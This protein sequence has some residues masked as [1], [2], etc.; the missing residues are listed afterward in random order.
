MFSGCVAQQADVV[1]INRDLNKKIARLDKSKKDLQQAVREANEALDKANSIIAQQRE[2]IQTL[3][4]ARAD[5]N[6]Q[7]MTLKDGDL[8]EVRG[9]ID[10]NRH[11]LELLSQQIEGLNRQVGL[12]QKE[13]LRRDETIQ[14]IVEQIRGQVT[15]QEAVVT[16]QAEKMTE[17]RTSF[18]DFQQALA[19]LR[20]TIGQQ[21]SLI[22]Q[23]N[24]QIELV[25]GKQ[26]T[27]NQ[28]TTQNFEEVKRSINSVVSALDKVSNTLANRL[29]EQDQKLNQI[30]A[31]MGNSPITSSRSTTI[32]QSSQANEISQ[33]VRQLR[34]EMNTLAMNLEPRQDTRRAGLGTSPPSRS[35]L[36]VPPVGYP[37]ETSDYVHVPSKGQRA[38]GIRHQP[39]ADEAIREYG[40]HYALLRAGDV[41]GAL[42]G[43]RQFLERYPNSPLASNAQYW[44]GE[45]YYAQRR[46]SQAIVEF[47]RVFNQY[48]SSEKVPAA[49]LKIGYSNLEL[50]EHARARAI[51]RQ[52]VRA[53][54]KTPEAAK[55][56]SRLTEFERMHNTSP[57]S[58]PL[59]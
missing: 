12:Y 42:K 23:A 19:T 37:Q 7:M 10:E 1:R 29:D 56:Y 24:S 35:P 22:Q 28:S 45:C 43:F 40:E 47:E 21:D 52:L 41:N 11:Q 8:S 58:G 53:Y 31:R 54:P 3:L 48:P 20:E 32:Q 34:E 17:F 49:L 14:P 5:L 6:D 55:A 30:S 59:S 9:A 13:A 50:Q 39:R 16:T 27:D 36:P 46:F 25:S 15:Q 38:E 44:L 51:F 57:E 26:R 4:Q 33:S 2:E 18:L